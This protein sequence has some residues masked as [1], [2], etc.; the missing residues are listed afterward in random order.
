MPPE[1]FEPAVLASER[2][3]TSALDRADTEMDFIYS[4]YGKLDNASETRRM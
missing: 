4:S 2:P 3:Q 1:G